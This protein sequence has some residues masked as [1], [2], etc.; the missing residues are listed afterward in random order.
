MQLSKDEWITRSVNRYVNTT[1][2]DRASAQQ[3]AERL[4]DEVGQTSSPEVA[5]DADVDSWESEE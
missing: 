1:S 2:I 4:Y 5:T 3:F